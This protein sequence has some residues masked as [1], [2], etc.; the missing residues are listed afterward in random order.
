MSEKLA[1]IKRAEQV[2][3]SRRAQALA[4]GGFRPGEGGAEAG[5]AFALV[6]DAD[7]FSFEGDFGKTAQGEAAETAHFIDY[8]EDRSTVCL[9]ESVERAAGDSDRFFQMRHGAAVVCSL[10]RC[11]P[12][13]DWAT[14]DS[15]RRP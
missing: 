1:P 3:L 8:A 5:E 7:Q 11:R 13:A 10:R 15:A 12:T 6:S 4:P 9:P 14:R 2:V